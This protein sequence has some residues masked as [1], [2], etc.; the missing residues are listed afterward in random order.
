MQKR[1]LDFEIPLTHDQWDEL[2]RTAAALSPDGSG[3]RWKPGDWGCIHV[4][5]RDEDAPDLLRQYVSPERST[6]GASER[7]VAHFIYNDGRPYAE[8]LPPRIP[9][10]P[11]VTE[12]QEAAIE[13]ELEHWVRGKWHSL[14]ERSG[15][16]YDRGYSPEDEQ[17]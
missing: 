11:S 14:M 10:V 17:L 9:D 13:R 8:L 7:E 2:G 12:G 15:L 1:N 4:S 5:L 3:F 6:Y 16:H